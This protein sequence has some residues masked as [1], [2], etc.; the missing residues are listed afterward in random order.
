MWV[1][2]PL[3]NLLDTSSKDVMRPAAILNKNLNIYHFKNKQY[4]L[5]E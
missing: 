3:K 5:K 2:L 4:Y 1:F